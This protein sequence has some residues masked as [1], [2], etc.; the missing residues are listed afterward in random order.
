MPR[1][2]ALAAF[3]ENGFLEMAAGVVDIL[4]VAHFDQCGSLKGSIWWMTLV[5]FDCGMMSVAVYCAADRC[6]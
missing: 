3:H 4:V 6:V 5:T 1:T 2:W